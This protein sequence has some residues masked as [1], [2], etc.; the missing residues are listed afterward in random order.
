MAAEKDGPDEYHTSSIL[1]NRQPLNEVVCGQRP[2]EV[3]EVEDGGDPAIALALET[4]IRDQGVGA[5][6]VEGELIKKL[7]RVGDAYLESVSFLKSLAI[8]RVSI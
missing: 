2:E 4:E 1:R 8:W 3:A 7:D 5:G 6:V